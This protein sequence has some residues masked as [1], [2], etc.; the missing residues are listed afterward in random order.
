MPIQE[1]RR[2]A[3][4]REVPEPAP[5]APAPLSP[6]PSTGATVEAAVARLRVE[7]GIATDERAI[8]LGQTASSRVELEAPG[9]PQLVRDEATIRLAGYFAQSDFGAV[10]QEAIGPKS[11]EY[12]MNHANAWRNSG[13]AGLLAPWVVERAGV[14]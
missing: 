6:W 14:I 11:V 4:E 2:A 7:T 8:A 9:A 12:A 13:A 10:R 3:R 1:T 5:A